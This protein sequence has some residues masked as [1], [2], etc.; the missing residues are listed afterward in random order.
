MPCAALARRLAARRGA[1]ARSIAGWTDLPDDGRRFY[2]DPFPIVWRGRT[3]LFVEEFEHRRGKGVISAVEFGA[4][5][6]LGAPEP[7]LE[8]PAISPIRSCSSATARCG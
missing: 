5:G 2:A 7:V 8:T 6:P 3:F 1:A 4:D